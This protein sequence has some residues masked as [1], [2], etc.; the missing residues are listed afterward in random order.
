MRLMVSYRE[1]L[2]PLW[3]TSM[4]C[5]IS[6]GLE[7]LGVSVR[8]PGRSWEV[9]SVLYFSVLQHIKFVEDFSFITE[10]TEVAWGA[11]AVQ[12]LI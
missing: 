11:E 4:L 5:N 1:Y 2:P 7:S 3:P 8:K 6:N 9:V 10:I 12:Y